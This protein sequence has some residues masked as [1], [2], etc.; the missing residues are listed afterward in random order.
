MDKKNFSE[1]GIVQ[2][3]LPLYYDDVCTPASKELVQ[4]HLEHCPSCQALYEELEDRSVDCVIETESRQVLER[5]ARKERT[6]AWKAGLILE[7]HARKERTAAW[8]AGLII[9]VLL[10]IPVILTFL[11]SIA[12][13]GGLGVFSVTTASMLLVAALTAVPLMTEQKKLTKS[14]L[15]GIFALLLILFFVDRM[16][17]GGQFLLLAIPTIFGLSVPLFPFVIRGLALPP[18]LSDKKAL[19][20]MVWDTAWLFL[21]IFTVC[22]HSGD[23]EGLRAGTIISVILMTGV[24]L[25]FLTARYLPANRWIKAGLISLITGI[26]MAF[27]SDAYGLIAEH[28]RQLTILAADFSDWTSTRSINADIYLLFLAAGILLGILCIAI[29]VT[30]GRK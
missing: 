20:T 23:V 29:G 14:I 3:L 9:S 11:F 1:C 4:R 10:L 2:D 25:I 26:W 18:V 19:L 8:K 5:H 6:A 16:N 24:W 27:S 28:K 13:G 7:R 12:V 17:G 22:H 21:T 15:A 30:R